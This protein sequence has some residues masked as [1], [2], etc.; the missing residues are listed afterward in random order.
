[1]RKIIHFLKKV[2]EIIKGKRKEEEKEIRQLVAEIKEKIEKREEEE[3]SW[4]ERMERIIYATERRT[5]YLIREVDKIKAEGE[6][7]RKKRKTRW[8]LPVVGLGLVIPVGFGLGIGYF[9]GRLLNM[10]IAIP[11]VVGIAL[12]VWIVR[13]IQI[14][15]PTEMGILVMFG[16]P[17]KFVDSGPHF[18][19]LPHWCYIVRFPK[20][21]YRLDFPERIVVSKEGEY[22]KRQYGAQEIKVDSTLYLRFPRDESLIT[23]YEVHVPTGEK[24]L[25]E[26]FEDTALGSMR[27]VLATKTWKEITEKQKDFAIEIK[28]EIVATEKFKTTGISPD[29]VIFIIVEV[30][31]PPTLAEALVRVDIER[32]EAEAATYEAQQSTVETTGA[33][34]ITM[35]SEE[36]GLEPA[37]IRAQL[38]EDPEGFLK[39]YGSIIEKN[40]DIIHRKIAIEKG[41]YVDIRTTASEPVKSLL[42]L[43]AAWKRL[44]STGRR[45]GGKGGKGK[46]YTREEIEEM[47]ER[48]REKMRKSMKK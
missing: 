16:V 46:Y 44:P 30:R 14:I 42:E 34:L 5:L 32:L 10:G 41:L 3:K 48:T 20:K 19:P 25:T 36:L 6:E 12:L 39:R 7:K 45:E 33:A 8:F 1:V 43:L 28:K 2:A 15:G 18:V 26:F 22:M 38:R 40:W 13:S 9:L 27:A 35:V 29:D 11:V 21:L 17:V 47:Q 24:E 37:D 23:T 31:L 4:R